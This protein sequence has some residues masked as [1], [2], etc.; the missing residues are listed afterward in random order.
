LRI[1]EWNEEVL[2]VE[3]R[4]IYLKST[5]IQSLKNRA[6]G[7]ARSRVRLCAHRDT[8][9]AMHEMLIV[10]TRDCYVR[11]HKHLGKPESFHIVEGTADVVVFEDNGSLCQVIPMGD[12]ASGRAFYYRISEPLYHTVLIRSAVLA[13]HEATTGPF[14]RE[15]TI[16]APWAP[17]EYDT[18]GYK[19]FMDSLR[20]TVQNH[21]G[22][23][24]TE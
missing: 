11:P 14:N 23:E 15:D 17:E 2:F 16:F 8:K 13:F 9:D 10:H 24:A 7:N 20:Q 6:A 5:D 12:Y 19:A 1:L 18:A 3:D 21:L 22:A 4:V